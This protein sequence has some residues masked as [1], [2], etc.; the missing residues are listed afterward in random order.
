MH[1]LYY[2]KLHFVA[3]GIIGL[4]KVS[5]TL[6]IKRRHKGPRQSMHFLI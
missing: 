3:I 1:L 4:Y 2:Y 5:V 6:G